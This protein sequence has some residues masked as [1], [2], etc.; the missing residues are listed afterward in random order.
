MTLR[1]LAPLFGLSKSAADRVIRHL[2]ALLALRPRKRFR[3]N[4]VLIVDGTLVPTRDRTVA[5]QSKN[6]R[7]NLGLPLQP[8]SHLRD[9]VV[10]RLPMSRL[11]RSRHLPDL[12]DD[13]RILHRGRM[14]TLP[15]LPPV[16]ISGRARA[17]LDAALSALTPGGGEASVDVL[18][19]RP[20]RLGFRSARP[21]SLTILEDVCSLWSAV[22]KAITVAAT[23][24]GID[25]IVAMTEA[26]PQPGPIAQ[27]VIA[28][29]QPVP[30]QYRAAVADHVRDPPYSS[31]EFW[32]DDAPF[33]LDGRR[34]AGVPQRLQ[35]Q[36]HQF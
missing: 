36:A 1:R 7:L 5:A 2:G 30:E 11:R 24:Q 26:P 13:W 15:S 14:E 28:A 16:P 29:L 6:Y 21:P 10:R 4:T 20:L 32:N 35:H 12:A 33:A 31:S 27:A 22:S 25:V 8:G 9:A 18:A 34:M 3:K 19:E 23:E 17:V